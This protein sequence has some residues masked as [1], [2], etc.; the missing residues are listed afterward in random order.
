MEAALAAHG[1]VD[2]L[3]NNVGGTIWARPYEEYD[4]EK[5]EKEIRR[6]LFPTLWTCRAVLPADAGAGF[7]HHRQ[8][9][10][11]GHPRHAPGAR[12]R[13]RRAASTP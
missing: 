10:L 5:I 7:G 3:V 12:M 9:F 8:R 2:V 4:E 11:G 6:S 13:R 1:R